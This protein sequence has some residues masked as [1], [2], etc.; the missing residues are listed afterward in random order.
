VLVDR[1][2]L[3][4]SPVGKDEQLLPS[5]DL[6]AITVKSVIDA[7]KGTSG[8][9]DVPATTAVDREIDRLLES[10]D[11]EMARSPSNATLRSLAQASQQA[12]GDADATQAGERSSGRGI[13]R[14]G[15]LRTRTS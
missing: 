1:K 2:L 5:R 3:V 15:E 14:P 4:T 9:V 8:P 11:G 10:L 13:S 7:L 6:D 12:L